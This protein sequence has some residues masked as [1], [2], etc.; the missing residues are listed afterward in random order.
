MKHLLVLCLLLAG[1]SL[2]DSPEKALGSVYIT[3]A[4]LAETT[5]V[6]L[7]AGALTLDQAR[8]IHEALTEAKTTADAASLALSVGDTTTA[9]G[10]LAAVTAILLEVEQRLKPVPVTWIPEV[11]HESA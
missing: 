5:T 3:I 2:I 11:R 8:S 6:R 1:C 9:Q 4:A 10:K 7:D